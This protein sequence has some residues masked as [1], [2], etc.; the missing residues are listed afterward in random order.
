MY[1]NE[2]AAVLK[3]CRRMLARGLTRGSGGNI[4]V[5]I[6]GKDLIAISGSGIDYEE[7]TEDDVV[8]TDMN[9]NIIDGCVKPSSELPM[10]IA[11]Y[12]VRPDAGAV[13]HTHSTY[14]TTIACLRRPLRNV[15]YMVAFAGESV[16]CLPF[17]QIGSQELAD[18][19]AAAL[20]DRNAVLLGNHGLLAV[21]SN[22][23]NA[24]A[25]AEEIELAAELDYRTFLAGGGV[26]LTAED[27]APL[28]QSFKTYVK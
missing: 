23:E 14:C 20:K 4:S 17:Y 5:R 12:R 7:M 2:K 21:G 1:N 3:F 9:G 16:E 19:G 25:V 11:C 15:S 28:V 22:I 6:P 26:E 27:L 18:N 24:F 13:V 8:V 10:H